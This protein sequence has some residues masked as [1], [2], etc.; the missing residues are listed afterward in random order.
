MNTAEGKSNKDERHICPLQL[1]L[2]ERLIR[3]YSNKH[4]VVFDPFAGIGSVPHEAI[5]LE[6]RAVG[7]ELKPEY[8][9]VAKKNIRQAKA[10]RRTLFDLLEVAD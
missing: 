5:R 2:I 9:R 6:R 8:Y 10:Q 7:I 3:L 4:E 1:P